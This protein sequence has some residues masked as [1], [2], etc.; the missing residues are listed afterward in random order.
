[1]SLQRVIERSR[2]KFLTQVLHAKKI[3]MKRENKKQ[4]YIKCWKCPTRSAM[5]EF[6]LFLMELGE[7]FLCHE[8]SPDEA[9]SIC[10]AQESRETCP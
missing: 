2:R 1:M 4:C 10:L 5:H 7:E 8:G 6:T 9:L 3:Q